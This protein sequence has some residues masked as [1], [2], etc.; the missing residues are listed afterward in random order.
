ML[1]IRL[2]RTGR[3]KYPTYR[4]VA[5]DSKRAATGKVVE[6]LGHYNPHTKELVIKKDETLNRLKTGAQPSNTVVKLLMREKIE[7]PGWVKLKTKQPAAKAEPV[8]EEPKAEKSEP[9]VGEPKT[10]A[11]PADAAVAS[12]ESPFEAEPSPDEAD[13]TPKADKA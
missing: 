2:A 11:V 5:A 12:E 9:A 4:I 6:I 13:Q 8:V 10:E 7:M 3:T 1:V